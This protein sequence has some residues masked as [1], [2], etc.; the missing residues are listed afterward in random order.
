MKY[1]QRKKAQPYA[2]TVKH[3]YPNANP[4]FIQRLI[5]IQRGEDRP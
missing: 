2:E 5:A 3:R 4:K 1:E